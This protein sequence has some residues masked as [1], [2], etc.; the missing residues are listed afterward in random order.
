MSCTFFLNI[1]NTH[2]QVAEN[3]GNGLRLLSVYDTKSLDATI[4]QMEENM[5]SKGYAVCVVPALKAR[6]QERYGQRLYFLSCRDFAMLDFSLVDTSTLGMDRIA[7]AAAA[8]SLVKGP[9]IVVDCGT[10]V[11][12]V[13][14]DG[15]GRFLG[16][17]IS[18]GRS[19]MRRA[20]NSYTAQLPLLELRDEIPSPIGRNTREA[21]A[22]GTDLG[23]VGALHE[24]LSR[25][26]S[27]LHEDYTIYATGGDASYFLKALPYLLKPAPPLLT[28]QGVKLAAM[29]SM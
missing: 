21:M 26:V 13:I 6:L 10:C 28:L 27:Q 11:N 2:T 15:A 29:A 18:P 24:L 1:G 20:L 19:I 3:A 12:T 5:G 16:G 14:V 23:S 8:F 25:T 17:A 7:N 9:V 4:P 22:A